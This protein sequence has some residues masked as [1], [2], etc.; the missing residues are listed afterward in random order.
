MAT[1]DPEVSPWVRL[2]MDNRDRLA[3]CLM[4]I[5]YGD[6]FPDRAPDEDL[7][8][9]YRADAWEILM[10]S[11]HLLGL[12]AEENLKLLGLLKLAP[13]AECREA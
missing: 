2:L 11:P 10:S 4:A 8:A 13:P 3:R 9:N 6:N 5:A 1:Y 12:E 7:L